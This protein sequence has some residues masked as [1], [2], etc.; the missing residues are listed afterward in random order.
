L[1]FQ[2]KTTTTT[3]YDAHGKVV[4]EFS[5]KTTTWASYSL[6]GPG[7]TPRFLS[8]TGGQD[9]AEKT[10]GGTS[11]VYDTIASGIRTRGWI[12]FGSKVAAGV[13]AGAETGAGIMALNAA[14]IAWTAVR[15]AFTD[16]VINRYY[17]QG[18]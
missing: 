1:F 5:F 13:P 4:D 14:K 12:A 9:A 8:G 11:H 10:L 3:T 18:D 16:Y 17:H 15:E 7:G 2:E 6:D